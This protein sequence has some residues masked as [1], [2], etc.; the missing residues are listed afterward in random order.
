MLFGNFSSVAVG[1][2][3]A[4]IEITLGEDSDDFSKLLQSVRA[5]TTMDVVVTRAESF[6][7]ITDIVT[8]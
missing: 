1:L 6:A 8:T 3:G 4:G 5:V 7:A 2:W